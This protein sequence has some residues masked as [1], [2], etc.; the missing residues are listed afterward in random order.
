[1]LTKRGISADFTF[2][3]SSST[4]QLDYIHRSTPTEEIYFVRNVDSIPLST[5]MQFRVK[6]MQP[7]RWNPMT[8]EMTKLAVYKED[9]N[10]I[11]LAMDFEAFGSTFIIFTKSDAE[12]VHITSVSA[13]GKEI[14]P[15]QKTVEN[16]AYASSI[17]NNSILFSAN[18]AADYQLK[19]SDGTSKSITIPQ[20]EIVKLNGAWDVRFEQGWGFDPIQKF[21]SLV[22]WVKHPNE[23]IKHYSGLASYKLTFT[24]PIGF[25]SSN[26]EY[27]LD[28]GKVGEVARIFLNGVEVGVSLFPPHQLVLENI[29]R[30]GENNMVFEVANTWLNQYLYDIQQPLSLQRLRTN[31]DKEDF[32]KNG[33]LP[34][35][36]GLMGPV[37]LVSTTKVQIK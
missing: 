5:Q 10:G 25:L 30:E 11:T 27:Q 28:L 18:K 9:K 36:S 23:A 15:A 12:S 35:A 31:V 20:Q 21:D 17:S 24:L 6:D 19:L 34:L 33:A 4:S 29:L 16:I 3:T 37:Q 14:F 1:M 8:G 2:Q 26:K 13:A 22:D 32:I 7:Q